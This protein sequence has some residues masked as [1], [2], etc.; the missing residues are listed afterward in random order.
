MGSLFGGGGGGGSAPA[1]QPTRSAKGV[2]IISKF[3]ERAPM[4]GGATNVMGSIWKPTA[5]GPVRLGSVG[6]NGWP[7]NVGSY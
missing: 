3:G 7:P 2:R 1:P 4:T 6:D 5:A